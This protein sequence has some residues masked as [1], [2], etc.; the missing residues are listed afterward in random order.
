MSVLPAS[1]LAST[2]AG[3]R[4]RTSE[5]PSAAVCV[6]KL[7]ADARDSIYVHHVPSLAC[8]GRLPHQT[9]RESGN[10]LPDKRFHFGAE[11]GFT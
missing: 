2:T 9:N 11:C 1:T 6:R 4:L 5:V 3:K 10:M 8:V 7:T